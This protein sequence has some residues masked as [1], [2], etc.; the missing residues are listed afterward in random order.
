MG[1]TSFHSF[2][3]KGIVTVA[4]LQVLTTHLSRYPS[5]QVTL[6]ILTNNTFHL[7]TSISACGSVDFPL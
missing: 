7:G 3:T 4:L 2:I 1:F 5:R 6:L